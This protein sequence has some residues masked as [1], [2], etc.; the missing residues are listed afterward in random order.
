MAECSGL[1]DYEGPASTAVAH[2]AH[3]KLDIDLKN[4]SDP[5]WFRVHPALA[6][7][8]FGAR[9]KQYRLASPHPGYTSLARWNEECRDGAFVVTSTP[10]GQ[11]QRAYFF[12]DRIVECE[13]AMEWLQCTQRCGAPFPG[14][15]IDVAVDDETGYAKKPLPTCPQCGSLARPNV[16]LMDDKEWDATRTHEQEDRLNTWVAGLREQR[17]RKL[18]IVECGAPPNDRAGLR[19]RGERLLSAMGGTLIRIDARDA[20]LA[21][22][23]VGVGLAPAEALTAIDAAVAR[24]TRR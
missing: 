4:L 7:G 1:P 6:W 3:A 24:L 14:G 2:P 19:A 5:R 21:S 12:A 10:D 15:L 16:A 23:N 18:V 17:D 9:L 13:G 22:P 8:F 20:K 11:F